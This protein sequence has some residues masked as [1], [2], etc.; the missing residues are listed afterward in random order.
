VE[1]GL[2][3]NVRELDREQWWGHVAGDALLQAPDGRGRTPE[4][5]MRVGHPERREEPETLEMVEV[6]V[7]EEEVDSPRPFG[8]ELEAE[9]AD[10]G[11]GVEDEDRSVAEANLEAGRVSS[12]AQ[13][14]GTRR[15]ERSAA[16]PDLDPQR[17]S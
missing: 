8:D 14:P 3:R 17:S 5:D 13:R 1:R 9:R 4:V 16:A 10:A 15:R 7:G 6:K 12:V 2:G 11:S